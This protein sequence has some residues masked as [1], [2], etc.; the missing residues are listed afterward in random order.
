MDIFGVEKDR[1]KRVVLSLTEKEFELINCCVV[2][3]GFSMLSGQTIKGLGVEKSQAL[4]SELS[5]LLTKF[6]KFNEE[7]RQKTQ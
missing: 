3:S 1:G 7:S 5:G 4:A 6:N 2:A